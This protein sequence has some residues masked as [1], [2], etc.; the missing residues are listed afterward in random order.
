MPLATILA[1]QMGA[2]FFVDREIDLEY[3]SIYVE[4]S[5][6]RAPKIRRDIQSTLKSQ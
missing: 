5:R 3:I 6:G 1:A 2:G 4:L